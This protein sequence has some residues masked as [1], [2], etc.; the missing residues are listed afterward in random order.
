M[1]AST[2]SGD[3]GAAVDHRD[4]VDL[5]LL[6]VLQQQGNLRQLAASSTSWYRYINMFE[7]VYLHRFSVKQQ[8]RILI[9]LALRLNELDQ[10]YTNERIKH[11]PN[12]KASPLSAKSKIELKLFI[13]EKLKKFGAQGYPN[14]FICGITLACL[15]RLQALTQDQRCAYHYALQQLPAILGSTFNKILT[16]H[17][18]EPQDAMLVLSL[19]DARHKYLALR[20]ISYHFVDVPESEDEPTYH[21]I[22]LPLMAGTLNKKDAKMAYERLTDKFEDK[23][24]KQQH[25]ILSVLVKLAAVLPES[26]AKTTLL[27]K[28]ATQNCVNPD[29]Q[30]TY[31]SQVW[32]T[33]EACRC[34]TDNMFALAQHATGMERA[35]LLSSLLRHSPRTL[36]QLFQSEIVS[37]V[38]TVAE[39]KQL[40]MLLEVVLCYPHAREQILDKLFAT[41]DATLAASIF[42]HYLAK[43]NIDSNTSRSLAIHSILFYLTAK[44]NPSDIVQLSGKPLDDFMKS[45]AWSYFSNLDYSIFVCGTSLLCELAERS[46]DAEFALKIIHHYILCNE[47]DGKDKHS[48]L[49]RILRL[50]PLAD[51]SGEALIFP[52]IEHFFGEEPST[53]FANDLIHLDSTL[54]DVFDGVVKRSIL[55][56]YFTRELAMAAVTKGILKLERENQLSDLIYQ[57]LF[58]KLSPALIEEHIGSYLAYVT[59]QEGQDGVDVQFIKDLIKRT[60]LSAN[61]II[62]ALHQLWRYVSN[63]NNEPFI[64]DVYDCLCDGLAN[65]SPANYDPDLLVALWMDLHR[66]DPTLGRSLDTQLRV[67][68]KVA[69]HL[70]LQQVNEVLPRLE[71][72]FQLYPGRGLNFLSRLSVTAEDKTIL[73]KLVS[74]IAGFF[75]Q[76]LLLKILSA[77]ESKVITDAMTQMMSCIHVM[78]AAQLNI[79]VTILL[80]AEK[81]IFIQPIISRLPELLSRLSD[82]DLE[83]ITDNIINPPVIDCVTARNFPLTV[84]T[85]TIH[86][87]MKRRNLCLSKWEL[88]TGA[89]ATYFGS[90]AMIE[91]DCYYLVTPTGTV[92]LRLPRK[93]QKPDWFI[94]DLRQAL[95]SNQL[96]CA[97]ILELFQEMKKQNG[98]FAFLHKQENPVFDQFRF[99]FSRTVFNENADYWHTK[100]YMQAVSLL[101]QAYCDL[102]AAN[103]QSDIDQTAEANALL[104]YVP[105]NFPTT[106]RPNKY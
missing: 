87:E 6:N 20:T 1:A 46:R 97:N 76:T 101:Q 49:S 77:P 25:I 45:F 9:Q 51:P 8:E 64:D 36:D 80:S 3:F 28:E 86:A 27:L 89:I 85:K 100:P 75:K 71:E 26:V 10:H 82:E 56:H 68:I 63:A 98:I 92:Q 43:L 52:F 62:S 65:W 38:Q 60:D 72:D 15:G 67:F 90:A 69:P 47:I 33:N 32:Q 37:F 50:M 73:N 48:F 74:A 84:I 104:T 78:N 12:L 96:S 53:P 39:H 61:T 95:K 70:T 41:I 99:F 40:D 91:Q 16:G 81:E 5:V 13:Q 29:W 23:S 83:R 14:P 18:A 105:E 103:D 93:E 19:E 17:E 79:A 2:R 24:V 88:Q 21:A 106:T 42:Q 34:Q 35:H 102:K 31:Y 22:L 54:T 30:D 66:Y 57:K 44:L 58:M 7:L 55:F 4:A 59:E 94:D 11:V